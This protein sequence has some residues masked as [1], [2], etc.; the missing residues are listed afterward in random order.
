MTVRKSLVTVFFEFF[1]PVN[2]EELEEKMRE[3]VKKKQFPPF[4][5][6]ICMIDHKGMKNIKGHEKPYP[7]A[8]RRKR[9]IP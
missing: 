8:L 1:R 6:M 9:D 2:L 5:T 7:L 3:M 4:A